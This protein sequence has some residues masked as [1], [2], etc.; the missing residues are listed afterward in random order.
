MVFQATQCSF[1]LGLYNLEFSAA[2]FPTLKLQNSIVICSSHHVDQLVEENK[3]QESKIQ[4]GD[5]SSPLGQLSILLQQMLLW[6][7]SR[8]KMQIIT[9]HFSGEGNSVQT[10][11][12]SCQ[13]VVSI[14]PGLG[15]H[16]VRGWPLKEALDIGTNHLVNV[17]FPRRYLA[18][19][20]QGWTSQSAWLQAKETKQ[21]ADQINYKNENK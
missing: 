14:T 9:C 8:V 2:I 16:K 15:W 10:L 19:A 21:A 5:G 3:I 4:Q 11:R 13:P 18:R 17:P 20:L 12:L 7:P 1:L 6:A